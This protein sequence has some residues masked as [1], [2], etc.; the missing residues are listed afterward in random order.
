MV[1]V[2]IGL[3]HKGGGGARRKGVPQKRRSQSVSQSSFFCGAVF[4]TGEKLATTFG[5]DILELRLTRRHPSA[6]SASLVKS[7]SLV[8]CAYLNENRE[9]R[10]SYM[11]K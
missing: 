4:V 11:N 1:T 8:A 6:Q 10:I 2:G 5:L 9:K 3:L 7:R